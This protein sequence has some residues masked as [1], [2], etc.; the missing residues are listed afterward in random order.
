MAVRLA[1]PIMMSENV[2]AQEMSIPVGI[3]NPRAMAMAFIAWFTAPAPTH[4]MLTSTPSFTM[5]AMAPAT[6]AGDD[7]L[8]TLRKS[9]FVLLGGQ[10]PNSSMV[11]LSKSFHDS[12]YSLY[13][14]EA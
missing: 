1:P 6:D 5:P 10:A 14:R 13:K 2:G 4:C 12:T 3:K 9:M 11:L 7:L 8:D